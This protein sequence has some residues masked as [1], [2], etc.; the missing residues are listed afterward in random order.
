MCG[1]CGEMRFDKTKISFDDKTELLNSIKFRGPDNTGIYNSYNNSVF[2]GHSRLSIIDISEKSNQPMLDSVLGMTIVFNGVIYNYVSLRNKL[3]KKGYSFTSDGDTEVIIKAYHFY[4]P[5]CLD[6][7]DGVFSFCIYNL[8]N[9]KFFIARD[10]F[11]IK[12]LYYIKNNTQIIFSSTMKSLINRSSKL[13]NKIGLNYHFSLHSVVP[14]PHTIFK[15][16]NK[17]EQGHYMEIDQDGNFTNRKYYSTQEIRINKGINEHEII[18]ETERLLIEALKKRLLVSDVPV[19]VLLSGGLD[20]SLIVAM[21][22]AHTNQNI[23]T[24]SIGFS[25]KDKEEGNEFVYSDLVSDKFHTN[26]KKILTND[27]ELYNNLGDVIKMMP[28]PLSGQDAAGFFLL[29]KEVSKTQKVVL[30]GQGADELFGGYFWYEKMLNDSA[31]D[32]DKFLNHYLDR[33][34]NDY[35]TIM[36]N[37]YVDNDYT[38]NLVK[39][40]FNSYQNSDM[41]FLDTLL[42]VDVSNLIVDDPVKRVDSMTM[43]WALETRVPFLDK[44]LVEFFLSVPSELKIKNNG[45]YYLKKLSNK[46]LPDNLINREK[47]YFPVPPLKILKNKFLD[48]VSDILLSSECSNRGIFNQ[49]TIKHLLKNPNNYFTK[50]NGNTLW[51]LALFESWLQQNT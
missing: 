3:I 38:Y 37:E 40:W 46:Y 42:R 43:S 4:G 47:F 9:K 49:K 33:T 35:S 32:I 10:R 2:L 41:S 7:I 17:L 30:S 39:E 5:K 13:I 20:S 1:I 25:D 26:H 27:E 31:K 22:S 15:D 12:P 50:L 16:I 36:D 8:K 14:A 19:G 11:G 44:N 6:E 34:F 18:E 29:A 51:H 48:Y 45:K 21:S 28:E 24:Y 23:N